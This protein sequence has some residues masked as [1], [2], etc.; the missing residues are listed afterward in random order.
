MGNK[1]S[2]DV[3]SSLHLIPAHSFNTVYSVDHLI[4][5]SHHINQSVTIDNCPSEDIYQLTNE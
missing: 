1:A 5:N 3:H 4:S 2:S